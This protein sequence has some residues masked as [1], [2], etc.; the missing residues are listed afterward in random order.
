RNWNEYLIDQVFRRKPWL[1][2]M[3][4]KDLAKARGGGFPAIYQPVKMSDF[5]AVINVVKWT[6][7]V[8]ASPIQ[9]PIVAAQW[10]MC[11]YAVVMDTLLT[12]FS[13][14]QGAGAPY[15]VI[16]SIKE[17][18]TDF[19]FAL[20]DA[21]DTKLYGKPSDANEI[22]GL[23]SAIDDGTNVATYG[24]LSRSEY[25]NWASVIYNYNAET[26]GTTIPDYVTNKEHWKIVSWYLAKYRK[27]VPGDVPGVILTSY[28]VFRALID[29]MAGIERTIVQNIDEVSLTR[30]AG[31][32]Q[33]LIDGIPVIP[34]DKITT[35]TLYY[36]NFNYWE[37]PTNADLFFN[38]LGPADL[39]AV[40]VL[41]WRIALLFG[42]NFICYAPRYN[43]KVINFPVGISL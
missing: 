19:Y 18:F 26:V 4:L 24:G 12:E 33:L 3:V 15:A 6:G 9:N 22:E 42:G 31:I 37:F 29:S 28:S 2:R 34:L 5:G 21:I 17:R 38:M 36:C 13:L 1:L 30:G 10:N 39:L 25:P 16:D 14:M 35:D 40:N 20:I 27:N 43:F 23:D 41:G 7:E 11:G 32:Q 8:T